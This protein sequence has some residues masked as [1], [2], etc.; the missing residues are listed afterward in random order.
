MHVYVERGGKTINYASI[1]PGECFGEIALLDDAARSA[2][3]RAQTPSRCCA[4]SKH[5]FL[6]I[7]QR[8]PHIVLRVMQSLARRL[9]QAS[10]RL[11]ELP[12]IHQPKA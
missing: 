2:S 12:M 9:R 6:D 11:Q 8:Y 7:V 3:V 5:D 4:L 1:H 10:T